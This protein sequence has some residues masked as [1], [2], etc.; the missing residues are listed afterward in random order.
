MGGGPGSG[1]GSGGSGIGFMSAVLMQDRLRFRRQ[2]RRHAAESKNDGFPQ[3]RRSASQPIPSVYN[4][5][6]AYPSIL[7]SGAATLAT[8]LHSCHLGV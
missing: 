2:P 3:R 6:E 4:A 8:D 7:R 1:N 5:R